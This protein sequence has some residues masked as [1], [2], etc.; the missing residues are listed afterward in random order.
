MSVARARVRVRL[1][2]T[3][4]DDHNF[5]LH[6]ADTDIPPKRKLEQQQY[7]GGYS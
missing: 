3:A 1:A 7:H 6:G 5:I 4:T 2:D